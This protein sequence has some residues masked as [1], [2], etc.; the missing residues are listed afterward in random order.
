MEKVIQIKTLSYRYPDG[1]KALN[2]ISFDI[3]YGERVGI[4]G[5]NGAGKTT[6]FLCMMG[7][8]TGWE[9]DVVLFSLSM[10][11]KKNHPIVRKKISIV[12]QNAD[13][14]LISPTVF[15]DV[16]FG[17]LN[18]NFSRD[19]IPKRVKKSLNDVGLNGF[20]NR[21]PFHLSGGEKRRVC[22]AGALA[23]EPEV[24]LVDEPTSDLDPRGKR[25]IKEILNSLNNTR[26]ISSHDLEF[27]LDTCDRV[28]VLDEGKIVADGIAK[29][30]LSDESLMLAH[31]LEKPHSLSPHVIPHH[32]R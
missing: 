12:F 18:H 30:I 29:E 32:Y 17:L 15:D 21:L 20:S 13:D 31:G 4:I 26:I 1:I 28:I 10:K 7:L 3:S 6:L 22:L 9:G 19:E 24:L 2:N 25:K 27:I 23:I 14:Q 5:P 16:A 11:D 8:I